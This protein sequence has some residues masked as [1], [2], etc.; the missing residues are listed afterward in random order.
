MTLL[1]ICQNAS[2][3][4]GFERPNSIIGSSDATAPPLLV[5][6]PRTGQN[7]VS[8]G[9]WTI[10]Q[11][12]HTFNTAS[13]TA[14][15][16]LPADFESVINDTEYNRADQE[17]M[18]G[19]LNAQQWQFVKSGIV[20]AG[21]QQRFRFKADSNVRKLFIDPTPTSIEACVFEY[22]SNAWCQSA[23]GTAQSAWAADTDTGILDEN[24]MEIGI[25]WRFQQLHGF[26]YA[27]NFREFQI[28]AAR[29]LGAD[30]GAP[31]L[32]MDNRNKFSG[33]PYGYNLPESGYGT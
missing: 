18:R 16:A 19:P 31:V 1:S 33:S 30:G 7:L 29:L 32:A 12:E 27:E 17:Q 10:L 25:T 21:T 26:D 6:A 2:D 15:Y 4:V 20:A 3:Y 5:C 28:N 24:L 11:K 23:G 14:S 9:A 22:V 8:R 13:G